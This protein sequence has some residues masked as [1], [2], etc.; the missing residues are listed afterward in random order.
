MAEE[1]DYPPIQ[2]SYELK[3]LQAENLRLKE[4]LRAS[5]IPIEDDEADCSASPNSQ[6]GEGPVNRSHR[7]RTT[8]QHRFQGSEWSDSLYFGSPGL[9]NVIN[10]V[11]HCS[12]YDIQG[13]MN[14]QFASMNVSPTTPYS[15]AHLTHAMPR[16]ADMYAPRDLPLYPFAT[17]FPVSLEEA[18]PKLL[19]CLPP[20][21]EL[22]RYLD[23]FQKRVHVC[24]FP[25]IPTE[26]TKSEVERFLSDPRK[27]SEKCPDMLGLLFAA[28]A[29]GSQ[30][31]VWDKCGGKWVAGAMEEQSK[32]GNVYSELFLD[33]L[34]EKDS[35]LDWKLPQ[36][37]KPYAWPPS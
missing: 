22:F 37:C 23:S 12:S 31:S 3:R 32:T 20:T 9:A 7:R 13:L 27:N 5:R 30:V 26:I 10:E 29:L 19:E 25:H 15:L 33:H 28:L 16:G 21:D 8:K 35:D 6:H 2:Q 4:R 36:P 18:I 17:L 34:F 11:G 1:G 14:D 24:F